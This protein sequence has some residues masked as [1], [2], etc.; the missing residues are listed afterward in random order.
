[1]TASELH[2]L[3]PYGALV[4][5]SDGTPRPPE[6]FKKKLRAWQGNNDA[7][8][9]T[10]AHPA[11]AYGPGDFSLQTLNSAVLVLNRGFAVTSTKTFIVSPR[12]AGTIIAYSEFE[13]RIEVRHVW[14]SVAHA[15]GWANEGRNRY[16]LANCGYKYWIVNGSDALEPWTPATAA[17]ASTV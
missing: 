15:H 5:F 11:S 8:Y 6:R 9:F 14:P 16:D 10:Q 1:M 7:G 17:P 2:A 12:P 4:K 3:A 13:G